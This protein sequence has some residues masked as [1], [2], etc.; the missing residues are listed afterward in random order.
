MLEKAITE[1]KD[2]CSKKEKS[3]KIFE[4]DYVVNATRGKRIFR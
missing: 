4:E 2:M 3:K 1:K